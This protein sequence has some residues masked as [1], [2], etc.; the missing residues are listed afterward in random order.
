VVING[1]DLKEVLIDLLITKCKVA[2]S[3]AQ[4]KETLRNI[5]EIITRKI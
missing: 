1:L 2:P 4:A 3:D 5:K